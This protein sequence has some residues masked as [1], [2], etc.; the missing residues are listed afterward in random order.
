MHSGVMASTEFGR[1]LRRWRD[2]VT[3]EAVGLSVGGRRRAT[4]LRREELAQLAGISVDYVT[5]LEQGRAVNPSEQVV[6]ALGRALRISSAERERLFRSAGLVPPGA[7]TVPTHLSPGV[8]RI[9]DRLVG[10]PVAVFDAACN[11]LMANPLYEAL[12]G[13]HRGRERNAVWRNFLGAPGRVRH[14]PESLLALKGAQVDQLRV[15]AERYPAD[16]GLGRLIAELR[17][18]S[19]EFADM[20]EADGATGAVTSPRKIVDHPDVG[21][22]AL[23]CDTLGVTGP[24][25]R[26]MVYTAEPGSADADRLA[27]LAVLGSQSLHE[28]IPGSSVRLASE[29]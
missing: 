3:P 23:D 1:T 16:R 20:W 11:E 24:D 6:E 26:I 4:G 28:E 22:V 5:R 8:L 17:A 15:A 29:R 12:M 19:G 14:S 2:R 27:L 18:D 13:E 10:T 25:L 9:L 7:G 21:P